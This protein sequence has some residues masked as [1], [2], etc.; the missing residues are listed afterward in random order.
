MSEGIVRK[1]YGVLRIG[2]RLIGVPFGHLAEV[3][4]VPGISKPMAPDGPL[5]GAFDL[6]G[7]LVPL[8]DVEVLC[9]LPGR[10]R[11][12]HKAAV[13]QMDQR[14][15]AIALDEIVTLIEAE[16]TETRY[17]RTAGESDGLH[18]PAL[19]DRL[20]RSGFV[21]D[22]RIVHCLDARM[23]FAL[24]DVPSV[25]NTRT[26]NPPSTA[27]RR[28][29]YLI[30]ST[31]GAHFGIDAE[32]VSAT[33]P[34]KV[35]DTDEIGGDGGLCL[36]FIEHHGWK[37]PVVH[38]NMALGL[39]DAPDLGAAEIV[40]LRFPDDKLLGLAVEA[41]ESLTSIDAGKVT[42][43]GALIARNGMLP[44]VHVADGEV[45]VFMIDMEAL[46]SE[47]GLRTISELT[48]RTSR[49]QADAPVD[50][51]R[52][53]ATIRESHRY[54][55]FEAGCRMAVPAEQV[56]RILH[57][58]R[59]IVAASD[60]PPSVKGFFA[61]ANHS[62]PLVALS[63]QTVGDPDDGFVL[64]VSA[65]GRQVGFTASRICSMQTSQWRIRGSPSDP[66]GGD[67]VQVSDR[68]QTTVLP[69]ADLMALARSVTDAIPADD[70]RVA[71]VS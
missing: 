17:G 26:A 49:R 18:R 9:G 60:M 56:A 65:E 12:I 55:V 38:T 51:G 30:V 70:S 52:A 14:I 41:T 3:C 6:R 54:L 50:A 24:P 20:F 48:I 25:G 10:P 22:G 69:V 8:V 62:V 46:T 31:G 66:D 64:L 45:Q 28:R 68:G 71:Q 1:G 47:S 4:V 5:L 67:L 23:L 37:V 57:M 58:P 44:R 16:P 59:S 33:V 39:G 35:I 32:H 29:K 63:D 40:V 7:N 42:E 61:V 27:A 36:G 53:G 43:S 34:K 11:P 2:D 13:L 19:P 15:A 21:M